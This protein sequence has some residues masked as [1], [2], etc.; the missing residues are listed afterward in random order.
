M[1]EPRLVPDEWLSARLGK[2]AFHL[3]G[4]PGEPGPW[5]GEVKQQLAGNPLFADVKVAVDDLHG[6]ARASE[7]GFALVDTNV[8]LTAARSAIPAA[9]MPAVG[10]AVPEMADV[11]G[12]IAEHAF[13]YDRFHRDPLTLPYAGRIK[14]DWARNFFAGK[15]GEWMVAA[16]RGGVAIG[17]LQLLRSAGDELII[18][19]IAVEA[20]SEG[21]G[22]AAAMISFAARNCATAGPMVVGTQVA[23][24]RSIRLYERLGFRLQSAQYVYHHHGGPT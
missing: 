22:I 1:T 18:D 8:R 13:V 12:T 4:T 10:F 19:L 3:N 6:A 7:L 20:A 17:F 23:N 15:R 5:I 16:S 2:R 9:D 24:T 11:I 14:R 21:Q